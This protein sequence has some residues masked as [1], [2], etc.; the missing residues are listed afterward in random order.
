MGKDYEIQ[1]SRLVKETGGGVTVMDVGKKD[2]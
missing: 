1:M 2:G